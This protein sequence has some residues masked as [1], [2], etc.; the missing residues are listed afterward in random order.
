MAYI[1]RRTLLERLGLGAG[2]FVLSPMVRTM[3]AEAAGSASVATRKRLIIFTYSN[4]TLCS[5]FIPPEHRE[6][7]FGTTLLSTQEFTMPD[8]FKPLAAYRNR[9]LLV[10]GLVNQN[11][12]FGHFAGDGL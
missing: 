5:H 8:R 12:N 7:K 4:G 1:N 2:A 10:D 11:K 6:K 3:L 9:M